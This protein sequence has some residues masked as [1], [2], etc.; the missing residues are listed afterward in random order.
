V[1]RRTS[2]G[3]AVVALM[4]AVRVVAAQDLL[5]DARSLYESADYEEALQLLNRYADETR[6]PPAAPR[7]DIADEYRALCLLALNR[8]DEAEL[9][10]ARI[11]AHNPFYVPSLSDPAPRF[12]SAVVKARNDVTPL[13]ARRIYDEAK[14]AFDRR[15]Y[16][17][18]TAALEQLLRVVQYD[19]LNADV[20]NGLSELARMSRNLLEVSRHSQTVYMAG[21]A[22]VQPAQAM[23][24]IVPDPSVISKRITSPRSGTLELVIDPSGAV[25]SATL[26]A[27]IHPDYDRLLLEAAR[28]WTYRPARLDGRSVLWRTTVTIQLAPG[29]SK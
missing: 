26:S 4:L 6:D 19:G 2:I 1:R 11:L 29:L 21:D 8:Q 3:S 18:A 22:G 13:V 23:S 14:A 16:N 17:E 12:R 20:V 27:P 24:Q 25:E 15:R 10:L 28:S 9:V 5:H 7:H